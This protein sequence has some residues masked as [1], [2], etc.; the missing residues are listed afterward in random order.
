VRGGG[1]RKGCWDA[2]THLSAGAADL[3]D[4]DLR[5]AR[6]TE[7][8]EAA[9]RAAAQDRPAGCWIEGWGWD[10]T[11]SIHDVA[12]HRPVFVARRD[13][14]AA[15]VNPAGRAI[16]G[17][18][19]ETSVVEEAAFDAARARLPQRSADDRAAA[20]RVRLAEL[21][22]LQVS[23]VDDIVESWGPDVYTRLRDRG[24]LSVAIRMWLSEGLS[25]RECEAL[26]REFP[27]ADP[28]LAAV[29]IKIFLDGTLGARTAA[30]SH[31]YADDPGNAGRLRMDEREIPERVR[32]WAARGW[33]VALHAIGDRAV[34]CALDALERAPRPRWGAH[35]IEH[36]QVVKR[37][38]LP[39]FGANG[40]VASV[41]PGHWRDDAPFLASRLGERPGVV[42][43]PLRSL[44]QFGAKVAL[45]SDWPVSSWDP[46]TVLAAAADPARGEEAVASTI[47]WAWYTSGPP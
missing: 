10:G 25:D 9:L 42:A 26:R 22:A 34:T 8:I 14:H 6:S 32:L 46:E 1:L 20:L 23:A 30:L 28:L 45:G 40:V 44:A 15:W 37:S 7:A 5:E 43:H 27:A 36:A 19:P 2:H 31:P 16:L 18:D 3:H 11:S 47:G 41:Q 35:R 33:P 13:G 21:A 29:G 12:P 24:E 4:L 39:R 38:D 17:L